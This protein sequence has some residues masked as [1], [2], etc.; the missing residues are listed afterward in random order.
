M[1]KTCNKFK[2][3]DIQQSKQRQCLAKSPI[4]LFVCLPQGQG[5]QKI[6]IFP[7]NNETW[8]GKVQPY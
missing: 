2:K 1:F 6:T 5:D 3:L 8:P 7:G 4:D